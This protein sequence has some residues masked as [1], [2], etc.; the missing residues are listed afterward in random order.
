MCPLLFAEVLKDGILYLRKQEDI[1][2]AFMNFKYELY[3]PD[4][5]LITSALFINRWI[6]D[7]FIRTYDYIDFLPMQEPPP[8]VYNTFTGYAASKLPVIEGVK[9]EDS[10]MYKH[11]DYICNHNEGVKTYVIKFLARMMQQPYNLTNTALLFKSEQGAGK[12]TLFDYIGQNIIGSAGYL[13]TEK[14]QLVF[15]KF[16]SSIENIILVVA[17]ESSG[18]ETFIIN[19]NIKAA[20]TAKIISIEHKG[21]DVYKMTNNMHFI[22][23]TNNDNSV[24]VGP[25]DRRF[26]C[27]ECDNTICNN[28]EYFTAL[29]NEIK[30][31]KFDRACFD[32]F[33]SVDCDNYDYTNN[34]PETALYDEMR[35]LNIGIIERFCEEIVNRNLTQSS[36]SG[37]YD[38]FNKF[39]EYSKAKIDFTPTKFGCKIKKVPGINQTNSGGRKYLIDIDILKQHLIDKYKM[40]FFSDDF[41]DDKTTST[42]K[43]LISN[44]D[45]ISITSTT[46]TRQTKDESYDN[47]DIIA[48]DKKVTLNCIKCKVDNTFFV[49][50][51]K[52]KCSFCYSINAFE[53]IN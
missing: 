5:N 28:F 42:N 43:P 26:V 3:V 4:K 22:F 50:N 15:G 21:K 33:M 9:F 53:K 32:F 2:K 23:L 27:I 18:K 48:T 11:I 14:P 49:D 37:L 30:S 41:I 12:D 52:N 44:N 47:L 16:N 39:T 29:V 51:I 25:G 6:Q 10:L 35:Q 13:N 1:T 24:N 34:R 46:T 20:I 45:S 40:E 36:P 38:M 31:K 19:E 7:E 17:N 8:N